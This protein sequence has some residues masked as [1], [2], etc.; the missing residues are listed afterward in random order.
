MRYVVF[1]TLCS[2]GRN[3]NSIHEA[4]CAIQIQQTIRQQFWLVCVRQRVGDKMR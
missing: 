2:D 4:V 3:F 1:H